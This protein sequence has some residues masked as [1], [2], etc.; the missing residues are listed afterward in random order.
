M[1][2]N[3]GARCSCSCAHAAKARCA[4]R[5]PGSG[6]PRID[7]FDRSCPASQLTLIPPP[8]HTHLPQEARNFLVEQYRD[9]EPSRESIELAL[10]SILQVRLL[11]LAP[12][13]ACPQLRHS[14]GA[15]V[16][17]CAAA[18]SRWA[19]PCRC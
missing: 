15:C 11:L 10:D 8:T 2:C 13:P 5:P 3:A 12:A 9:H 4:L 16:A 7:L 17:S 19:A 1:R 18:A 14:C 6:R